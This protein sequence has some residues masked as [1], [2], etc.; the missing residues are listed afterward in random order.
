[1]HSLRHRNAGQPL[2]PGARLV[3]EAAAILEISEYELLDLAYR[4]WYGRPPPA[5]VL[6]DAFGPYMFHGRT[7]FWAVPLAR[8]VIAL[9]REG[10]LEQ[11]RFRAVMRPP[12]TL[13]DLLV[14]AVQSVLLLLLFGLIWYAAS[15]HVPYP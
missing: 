7:P 4:E 1:M 11:S 14:A 3:I 6:S 2:D 12:P 9:Y 10:R 13:R 8:E 5:R 15:A